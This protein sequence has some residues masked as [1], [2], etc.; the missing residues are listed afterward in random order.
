MESKA[1]FEDIKPLRGGKRRKKELKF[2]M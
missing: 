2:F 1:L